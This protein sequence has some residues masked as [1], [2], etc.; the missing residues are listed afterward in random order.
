MTTRLDI[1]SLLRAPGAF[2]QSVGDPSL[3][4]DGLDAFA[5]PSIAAHRDRPLR[6]A[7]VAA[8]RGLADNRVGLVLGP[9]ES[10][11]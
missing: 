8:W 11:S 2:A 7:Q 1:L 4:M 6:P 3:W 10:D 9:P 5:I